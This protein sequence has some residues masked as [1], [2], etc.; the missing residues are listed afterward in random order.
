MI[1]IKKLINI[2]KNKKNKKKKFVSTQDTLPF[3]TLYLDGIMEL[4]NGLYSKSIQFT[5]INYQISKDDEK[6]NIFLKYCEFLNSFDSSIKLQITI[7]NSRINIDDFKKNIFFKGKSDKFDIYRYEFNNM[8]EGNL[9][10]GQND[11]QK[12][13]YLTFTVKASNQID[14]RKILTRVQNRIE[15]SFRRLNSKVISLKADDKTKILNKFFC[16]T[17]KEFTEYKSIKDCIAPDSF[18][19][20]HSHFK[21]GEKFARVLY[22]KTLPN[23]LTDHSFVELTEE[24][25]RMMLSINIEMVAQ[26]EAVR[27]VK[28]QITG[29]EGNKIEYQKRASKSGYSTDILPS[30]LEDTLKHAQMLLDDIQN[31]NQ[32]MFLV[33]VVWIHIADSLDELNKETENLKAIARKNLCTFSTLKYQQESGMNSTLPYGVNQL[34]IRRTLTTESLAILMPFNA[35]SLQEKRGIYYGISTLNKN[36]LIFD[37][38]KSKNSSAFIIGTPGSGKSFAAKR[39]MI[40]VFL[41]TDDDILIIDPEQEYSRL[42]QSFGGEVINISAGSKNYINPLDMGRNYSDIEDPIA[43]KSEFILS[44]CEFLV[45]GSGLTAKEKTIIDRCLKKTYVEYVQDFDNRKIPTLVDFHKTL[46]S[47]N[48]HEAKDLALALEIYVKGSL[49]I[50]SHKTNININ[51]RLVSFDIKDLGNQLKTL[52]MLVVLDFIWNR[53]TKNREKGKRTWIYMDEIYLLFSNEYSIGFLFKLYKRARKWGGVPTGITQNIEDLLKSK[54]ARSMLANS[55]FL[56]VFNQSPGDRQELGK[57]LQITDSQLSYITNSNEGEGLIINN[58]LIIPF[59]DRFPRES[60]LY[61]LMT[62]KVDELDS[63]KKGSGFDYEL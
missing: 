23:F 30:G 35:Q 20:K 29:M 32:K 1:D 8:L 6:E 37:R 59:L 18:E 14:A 15:D 55:D 61:K 7:N 49:S 40:N 51:N 22:L 39:E 53:I 27:Y 48:E 19:F 28:K 38:N 58:G 41:N 33:N 45:G 52:G 17:Q 4:G 36:M 2:E 56:L 42:V 24:C 54:E 11:I 57:L 50:F 25:N 5:D 44:L 62:T 13:M 3:D 16:D 9:R 60:K 63:F 34:D 12:E 26:D 47:Q 43:L 31:K 46:E 21:I 10:E